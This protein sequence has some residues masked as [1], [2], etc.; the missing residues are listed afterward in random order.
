[1]CYICWWIGGG[2]LHW[3]IAEVKS[4]KREAV[5]EFSIL[6][7]LFFPLQVQVNCNV[8]DIKSWIEQS[9]DGNFSSR[10]C[11]GTSFEGNDTFPYIIFSLNLWETASNKVNIL[12]LERS[13]FSGSTMLRS[14]KTV[15]CLPSGLKLPRIRNSLTT[16]PYGQICSFHICL[17]ICK[18]VCKSAV[19]QSIVYV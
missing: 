12:N 2:T 1:V 13:V 3:K 19:I 18:N 14:K 17:C 15:H 8:V 7:D 6:S 11:N 4:T 16:K 5:S 9:R 10:S